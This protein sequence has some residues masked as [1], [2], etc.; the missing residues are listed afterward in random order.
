MLV[1]NALALAT[2]NALAEMPSQDGTNQTDFGKPKGWLFNF[3][4]WLICITLLL[5]HFSFKNYRLHAPSLSF[6]SLPNSLLTSAF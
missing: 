6:P 2:S 4:E 5:A 3:L 1:P